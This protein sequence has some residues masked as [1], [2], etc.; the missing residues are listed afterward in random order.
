MHTILLD[1][2]QYSIAAQ[3][4]QED[5]VVVI[6]TETVYG[7]AAKSTSDSACKEIYRIKNRAYDNPLII[8]CSSLD[9]V[10]Q[11]VHPAHATLLIDIMT[12][13]KD[14]PVTLIQYAS[15]YVSSTARAGGD[16]I[17][18]RIPYH[19]V[20]KQVI[21]ELGCPIAAP[22]A[23]ISGKPSA[24]DALMAWEAMHGKVSAVLDGGMCQYGLESTI[25]DCTQE[26]LCIVR[27]GGVSVQALTE[28]MSLL[29]LE[30]VIP[31]EEPP[32]S[33]THTTTRATTPGS[34]Y[35]HYAPQCTIIPFSTRED[36]SNIPDTAYNSRT[37]LCCI[38]DEIPAT[39]QNMF[40][41]SWHFSCWEDLAPQLFRLFSEFD[42]LHISH[43]Y[44]QCPSQN[45]HATLYDRIMRASATG[46]SAGSS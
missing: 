44:I 14:I 32:H 6:P 13:L 7:I 30:I 35:L 29:N 4:L 12:I 31:T 18:V 42:N 11:V 22:S 34:K 19:S 5:K 33:P 10:A 46:E 8:H 41:Y 38:G 40:Q 27:Y 25:I 17:A 43:A 21:T 36:I 39:L 24:T 15:E 26:K 16:T 20:C 23:N 45:V 2:S 3:L 37:A 1:Q 9:M 28:K